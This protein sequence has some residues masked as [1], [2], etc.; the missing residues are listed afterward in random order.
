EIGRG[1]FGVVVRA[2]HLT[3][4]QKVAIKILTEGEGSTPEEFAEDAARF[5][6]EARATAALRGDHVVR[7]L[8][9]DVLESGVPYIVMEFLEGQTLH[10]LIYPRGPLPIDDAIDYTLQVLAALA[11]AHA[12]GIVHRDLKPANVL[13]SKGLGGQLQAKVLDF[14]VSKMVGTSS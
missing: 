6:Q 8:D 7:V 5:R 4:D 10:D 13:L 2:R 9:V 12:A 14:G 1:G 3:L 11:E